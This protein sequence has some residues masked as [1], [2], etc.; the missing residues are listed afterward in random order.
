MTMPDYSG[1]FNVNIIFDL[2]KHGVPTL[3]GEIWHY[4]NDHSYP[5]YCQNSKQHKT[6]IRETT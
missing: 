5:Y 1:G 2:V 3:V 4:R 6:T